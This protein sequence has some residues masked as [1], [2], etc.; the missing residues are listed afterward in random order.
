MLRVI[1]FLYSAISLISFL[2]T[3]LMSACFFVVA[4]MDMNEIW[5]F[6]LSL[7]LFFL[8]QIVF[9]GLLINKLL[10]RKYLQSVVHK[11]WFDDQLGHLGCGDDLT[12]WYWKDVSSVEI[13]TNKKGPWSED[14]F[15]VLN[16]TDNE[17]C[18][19]IPQYIEN[20]NGIIDA[21][22]EKLGKVDLTEYSKALGSTSN[23]FFKI[24]ERA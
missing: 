23:N 9:Q 15:Y 12:S 6:I 17:E 8:L 5:A 16:F 21:I 22:H 2:S 1:E 19:V 14:F 7:V 10:F 18:L 11:F 20:S 4:R 3:G 24:W 13:H